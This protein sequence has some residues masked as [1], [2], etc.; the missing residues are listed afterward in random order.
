M[1]C[2]T[3]PGPRTALLVLLLVL[4][5]AA[6]VSGN[7]LLYRKSSRP[8]FHEADRPLIDRTIVR[9]AGLSRVPAERIRAETFPIVMRWGRRTCVELR[10]KDGT[11]YSGACFDRQGRLIEEAEGPLG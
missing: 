5:L 9:F 1:A 7:L 6:S 10:R 2:S 3:R 11:G 4:L 8:L